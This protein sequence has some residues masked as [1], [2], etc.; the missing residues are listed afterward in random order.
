MCET[1]FESECQTSFDEH[2]IMEDT[3]ECQIMQV[4]KCR[5][6][7]KGFRTDEVCDKW[8]KQ[9]RNNEV[10]YLTKLLHIPSSHN[11]GVHPGA[12]GEQAVLA[13]DGVPEEAQAGLRPG[14]LPAGARA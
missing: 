7:T 6:E 14:A 3:P 11:T 2:E 13:Q 5:E 10:D 1:V 9:V 12:E 8:P 4:E